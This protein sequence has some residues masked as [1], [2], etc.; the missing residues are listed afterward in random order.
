[1]NHVPTSIGR[2]A[3]SLAICPSQARRLEM[4]TRCATTRVKP[5]SAAAQVWLMEA[6]RAVLSAW[7]RKRI[8]RA[9]E[10]SEHLL[11]DI[12]LCDGSGRDGRRA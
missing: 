11:R 3:A 5:Q 2:R 6:I 12:G 10:L 8:L 9:G 1:M 7:S 4:Q